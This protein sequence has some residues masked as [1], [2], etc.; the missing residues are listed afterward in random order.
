MRDFRVAVTSRERAV[1]DPAAR[2][3]RRWLLAKK[4]P[5]AS[6]SNPPAAA[7]RAALTMPADTTAS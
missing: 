5:M 2:E 3:L 4:Q 7:A 6:A 1:F